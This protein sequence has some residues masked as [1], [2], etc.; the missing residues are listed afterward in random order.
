[1]FIQDVWAGREELLD[2]TLGDSKSKRS[3]LGPGVKCTNALK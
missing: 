2:A 3:L 1:M